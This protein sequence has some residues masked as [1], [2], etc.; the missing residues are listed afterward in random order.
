MKYN[1]PSHLINNQKMVMSLIN[2]KLKLAYIFTLFFLATLAPLGLQAQMTTIP[3]GSFIINMG[4]VPQ[5]VGNGLKPYGMIYDLIS[6]YKIPIKWIISSGKVKDGIDFS[7]N[8]VD[9]KGGP[10]IVTTDYR[11]AA[12]NLRIAYWQTQGVIGVT[13]TSP[14]E[15]PVA[16]TLLVSS[17]PRWTMDL[18]NGKV[19]VPYFTNAGIP[20][21][22]YSLTRTP[23][24][25]GTCDDIFVMPHAYPQWSTHSNLYFWNKTYHGSI[26]LSCTAGSELEDMYNPAD[27][28]QQTN[29]L[30]E[31]DPAPFTNTTKTTVENALLLY[32]V[33]DN[34]TPPYTYSNHGDQFMQ[35]M[36]TIDAAT[37]NGLEQVYI[38]M[39]PG[40]RSTTTIGAYDPR[41]PD[42]IDDAPNHR[43][44]II[45]YG[46]G[47]G[48]PDRGY[49]MIEAA[50][51]LNNAKLPANIAGQRVFFNFSFMAG[52]NSSLAPDVTGIP[53]AVSSGTPIAVSFAFPVGTNPAEYTVAWSASCGG[54]FASDSSAPTD[55]T[56]AIFTPPSVTINTS[57]PI[58]VTLTDACGRI[59]NT[60]K[61][62]TISCEMQVVTTLTTACNAASNG[63][64]AMA[65]TGAAGPFVWSWT[66]SGG[67][68]GSG[69]GT[70]ITTLTAGTYTVIVTAGNGDGS[71]KTFTVTVASNPA[72]SALVITP[73]N[74][75]CN[76]L[77]TGSITVANP[78]GGTPPFTYLW[79]DAVTTQNRSSLAAGAYSVTATDANG[80]TATSGTITLTQPAAIAITPTVTNISCNGSTTGA[81][82]LAVTGGTGTLTYAW[83]DG[84]TTQNR[85]SLAA[86][87]Y[88]VTV[89]DANN[90]TKTQTGMVV[91][92][93]AAA[94]SLSA[95]AVNVACYG[96]STGSINLTAT[97]GT[98]PYGYDWGGSISTEDRATLP[99][100]NYAVTVTDAKG[101][102]AVLSKTITQPV[103]LS[104]S[105][106]VTP[107]TCP[108]AADGAIN[109]TATGGTGT[110]AYSWTGP[111]TFTPTPKTTEDISLLQDGAYSVTVTDANSCTGTLSV[112]V[113][114]IGVSPEAPA[115][116]N[117]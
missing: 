110:Y 6:N 102:T 19:A 43:A 105:T 114:T 50:H 16:M 45:A 103:A 106:V 3:A 108:G 73:G 35:F 63:A 15:V 100:G 86:G 20:S 21:S 36:G 47:F 18:L 61:P 24:Q 9:Y 5:T 58:T 28:S 27:H 51:S 41:H 116:I 32:D 117:H 75:L 48:D 56:K 91:T 8:G 83:N 59:F 64:I 67:G 99:A 26:W 46:R 80:C 79:N 49:V 33:H 97:G 23:Q 60:S 4:I 17:V 104:L 44:A 85:T 111:V 101:C 69:T 87:T 37:Q 1:S 52:K 65:I 76:A 115:T 112:T 57:C 98:T 74:V 22:A 12:V 95:T 34:G 93:P 39:S 77:T 113:N 30:S 84:A 88:S 70:S 90:C 72:I 14:V 78:V 29:F 54:S 92:Q 10:F 89:T 40:W 66:R 42:R 107:E 7:Y 38:P 2:K 11:S 96:N 13:T 94:L 62:S 82:S 71:S 53:S 68:T 31:R 109:L 25:L 81:I 55:K